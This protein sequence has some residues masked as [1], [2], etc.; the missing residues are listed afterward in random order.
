MSRNK[1]I[2]SASNYLVALLA[3]AVVTAALMVVQNSSPSWFNL[4][5]VVLAYLLVINIVTQ[6]AGFAPGIAAAF[7]SFLCFNFFFI[8]PRGTLLVGT[9]ADV[10]VLAIFLI[11]AIVN[12]RLLGRAQRSLIEA[13]Q[14][15]RDAT[16]FYELSLALI[17]TPNVPDV[18]ETLAEQLRE[19][20]NATTVEVLLQPFVDVKPIYAIAPASGPHDPP[21]YVE[22]IESARGS[23]GEIRVWRTSVPSA[24]S[25]GEERLVR[26]FAGET[27]LILERMRT[28]QTETR[29]RVLEESDRLKSALLSSVSHELRTPLATIRAGAESLRKGLVAPQSQAGRELL[30][31]VSA[32]A[33]HLTKLVNNLLDMSKIES[34]ALKPQRE[35]TELS[36]IIN[37]TVARLRGE[38]SR[39]RLE[40][41]VSDDLPLLPVDPVQLDQV[42]TNLITNSVKYAPPNTLIRVSARVKDAQFMRVQVS[43]ESPG[44][45]P[46]DLERI[47]DKFYRVTD[48]DRVTGT[49]LGL[50][51]CKGIIEAHGGKIWASNRPDAD[52][53][54]IFSFTLPLTWNGA[55]PKAPP[56]ELEDASV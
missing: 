39:H 30:E 10:I 35:W 21:G 26:M 23:Y 40:V 2:I 19:I 56:P 42:F 6:V 48:A 13:E 11:V 1:R 17:S 3:V 8:D 14:R 45:P 53:G 28:A 16:R 51:I 34:G 31:E 7:I 22:P 12:S 47:F 20:L 24:L 9:V 29:A 32:A 38:L 41:D 18:A 37:G 5:I 25:P 49:G 54:F 50:S 55:S 52:R 27:A 33:D 4:P 15:E 44:L 43:N 46:E 36:E